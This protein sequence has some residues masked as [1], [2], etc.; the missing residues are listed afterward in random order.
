MTPVSHDHPLIAQALVGKESEAPIVLIHGFAGSIETWPIELIKS[1][2]GTRSCFVV[3]LPGHFP[4]GCD[5]DGR[6]WPIE[7]TAVTRAV[8]DALQSVGYNS[9]ILIG[10]STGGWIALRLAALFPDQVVGVVSICGFASGK[11]SGI[12]GRLQSL[13]RRGPGAQS[14]ARILLG[15][16]ALQAGLF[17]IVHCHLTGHQLT[18]LSNERTLR[19]LRT[20]REVLKSHDPDNLLGWL[21]MLR[22]ND[23][24]D[25]IAKIRTPVLIVHGENDP[26][27]PISA[28]RAISDNISAPVEFVAL[29]DTG[30]FPFL[31]TSGVLESHIRKWID[32][33]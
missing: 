23:S 17:R 5:H 32:R 13:A 11:L 31:E 33:L 18:S 1:I 15:L 25:L 16:V 19:Y 9:A 20:D 7:A 22:Q 12:L 28:G 29:S 4:A 6:H 30:H 3:S 8:A 24:T 21:K 2:S 26:V 14:I 27:I 10:H